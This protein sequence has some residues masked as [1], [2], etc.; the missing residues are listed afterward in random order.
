[1]AAGE[2]APNIITFSWINIVS[3]PGGGGATIGLIVLATFF[4]KSQRYRSMGKIAFVPSLFNINEPVIFGFPMVLNGLMAIP[5]IF[6]PVINI[7]LGYALTVM[8]IL[9]PSN[10]AGS[11]G[12]PIF[13]NALLNGGWRLLAFQIV[14]TL[15]SIAIYYPFFRIL[16]QKEYQLENPDPK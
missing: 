9:P 10:G 3:S 14:A 11:M 2:A 13:L 6:T 16:D 5:F 1:L 8:E 4:S 15:L 7:L 12:M